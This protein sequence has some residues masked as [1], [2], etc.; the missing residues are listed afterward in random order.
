MNIENGILF[1]S[2]SIDNTEIESVTQFIKENIEQIN[3]V[4]VDENTTVASSCL[5]ALLGSIKKTKES[6]S[7]AFLEN[8]ND[9]ENFGN[10][11]FLRDK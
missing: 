3:E 2:A 11:S 8:E 5:F 1:L 4:I 10:V 7:I 9:I 6:I